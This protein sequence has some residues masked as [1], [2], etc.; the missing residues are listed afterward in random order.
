MPAASAESL[1]LSETQPLMEAGRLPAA[2]SAMERWRPLWWLPCELSLQVPMARFT[3]RELLQLSCG[4]I[5]A[6]ACSR[7]SEIPLYA[8]GELIGWTEFDAVGDHIAARVTE[9]V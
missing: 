8:N 5:V 1:A 3:V 7:S 6:S 2:Q 4:S 9:L